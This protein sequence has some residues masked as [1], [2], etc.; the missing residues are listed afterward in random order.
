MNRIAFAVV[1]IASHAGADEDTELLQF[2]R[3][4]TNSTAMTWCTMFQGWKTS[5]LLS[6]KADYVVEEQQYHYVSTSAMKKKMPAGTADAALAFGQSFAAAALADYTTAASK[7]AHDFHP[8]AGAA[9]DAALDVLGLTPPDKTNVDV[10]NAV[11]KSQKAIEAKIDQAVGVLKV[12]QAEIKRGIGAL[13]TGQEQILRDM[14]K[15]SQEVKGGQ[16]EIKVQIK[17]SAAA[18]LSEMRRVE[19]AV[20]AKLVN[21]FDSMSS[22]MQHQHQQVGIWMGNLDSN[23]QASFGTL[24]NHV[25]NHFKNLWQ[26]ELR[27]QLKTCMSKKKSS[28]DRIKAQWGYL[29]KNCRGSTCVRCSDDV[30]RV[31]T[32][33]TEIRVQQEEIPAKLQ[34]A[35]CDPAHAL[36]RIDTKMS[37]GY[38]TR[39]VLSHG[40]V[41]NQGGSYAKGKT[42]SAM[43]MQLIEDIS[44]EMSFL[45]SMSSAFAGLQFEIDVHNARKSL[46]RSHSHLSDGDRETEAM[47]TGFSQH[48]SKMKF[49]YDLYPNYWI[50]FEAV[51]YQQFRASIFAA[52]E[53]AK[54][55]WS[56]CSLKGKAFK[57]SE[58]ILMTV[59]GLPSLL[60]FGDAGKDNNL[61]EDNRTDIVTD[62][63]F[64]D[65]IG[66][67]EDE[68]LL[69]SDAHLSSNGGWAAVSYP[70]RRRSACHT[71]TSMASTQC[72]CNGREVT[73]GYAWNC[74]GP[75][76]QMGEYWAGMQDAGYIGYSTKSWWG[77]GKFVPKT[78]GKKV[79][80]ASCMAYMFHQGIPNPE[81]QCKWGSSCTEYQVAMQW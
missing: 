64:G 35:N 28:L 75:V 11:E 34:T 67:I 52:I 62:G 41:Y 63:E 2:H 30:S 80:G 10:I 32:V 43:R 69:Q 33:L 53:S 74:D 40:A 12:G 66:L 50:A 81:Y 78:R 9:T 77:T 42:P 7:G 58:D 27:S 61:E 54:T 45:V 76:S 20:S 4:T 39:Q 73:V 31:R 1:T 57:L 49:L 36:S 26:D 23:M 6:F 15:M 14:G 3:A 71:H 68:A 22:E 37:N 51:A 65:S 8:L 60:E 21:G 38:F 79:S 44:Q 70:R 56:I 29:K 19:H 48:I 18:T 55:G 16:A 24:T 72:T 59:H 17:A 25:D 46:Q 5:N 47:A 13:G